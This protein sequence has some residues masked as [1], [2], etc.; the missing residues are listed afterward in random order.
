MNLNVQSQLIK[1]VLH[2]NHVNQLNPG[3]RSGNEPTY[4]WIVSIQT[5]DHFCPTLHVPSPSLSQILSDVIH[6]YLR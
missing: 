3:T 5:L 4:A 1:L 2:Q 6:S